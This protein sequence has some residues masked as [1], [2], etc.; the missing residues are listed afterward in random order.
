VT[1]EGAASVVEI[2]VAAAGVFGASSIHEQ[3][4]IAVLVEVAPRETSGLHSRRSESGHDVSS[5]K[6]QSVS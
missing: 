1:S 4:E 3:I 5:V 6:T 2:D